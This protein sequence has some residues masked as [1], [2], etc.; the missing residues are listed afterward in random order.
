MLL[1]QGHEL[2]ELLLAFG[3]L[4]PDV[5]PVNLDLAVSLNDLDNVI[6]WVDVLG[7]WRT[8]ACKVAEN[9][10]R[11]LASYERSVICREQV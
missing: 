8:I 2:V 6:G 10:G 3:G 11:V 4:V 9:F 7:A 5:D 1:R